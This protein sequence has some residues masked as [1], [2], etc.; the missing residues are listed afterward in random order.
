[1]KKIWHL[2]TICIIAL[3]LFSCKKDQLQIEE[4]SYKGTFTVTYNSGTH[5]GE[6][7]LELK[8]GRFSS[9]GNSNKIPAAA[10]GSYTID[11]NT[12]T[13]NDE[14]PHT[15]EFDWGLILDGQYKYTFD[16]YVLK[17]ERIAEGIGKYSYNLK[18]Q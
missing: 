17:L 13:F 1:M 14:N 7:I 8:N 2:S 18:V 10:S 4:G 9:T 12:I 6:T 3:L 5:S 16:G 15:A 11:K